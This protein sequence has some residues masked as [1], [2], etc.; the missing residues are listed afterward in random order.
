MRLLTVL[1]G[2]PGSLH[3]LHHA[4]EGRG[5][6][7]IARD[8]YNQHKLRPSTTYETRIPRAARGRLCTQVTSHKVFSKT[9]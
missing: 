9:L 5:D 4:L 7:E 3:L 2:S 6:L 8:A 1:K